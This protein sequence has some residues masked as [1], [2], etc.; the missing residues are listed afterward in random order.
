MPRRTATAAAT[1][2]DAVTAPEADAAT[3]AR[4]RRSPGASRME[5]HDS[6]P[7]SGGHDHVPAAERSEHPGATW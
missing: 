5:A 4:S 2:T 7:L 1:A 3:D 6:M